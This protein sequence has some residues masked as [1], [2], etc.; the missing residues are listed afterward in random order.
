MAGVGGNAVYVCVCDVDFIGTTLQMTSENI[1]KNS[2]QRRDFQVLAD[3]IL[4]IMN[5]GSR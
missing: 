5:S 2:V 3:S 4:Y 1:E